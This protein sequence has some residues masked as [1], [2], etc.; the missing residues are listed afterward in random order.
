MSIGENNRSLEIL[1]FG[2]VHKEAPRGWFPD[3]EIG[4]LKVQFFKCLDGQRV[5]PFPSN[6]KTHTGHCV[7]VWG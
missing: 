1:E 6:G 7:R 3:G 4:D 5:E 2:N